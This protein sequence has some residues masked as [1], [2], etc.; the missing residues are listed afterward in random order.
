M[1]TVAII[2]A[3]LASTRL[4][5]K[6][7]LPLP[8]GR[9]VLE[10]VVYR[11]HQVEGVDLVV[12]A[13][14]RGDANKILLPHCG[15]ASTWGSTPDENDVLGRYSDAARLYDADRILRVTS[16][17]PLIDPAQCARVLADR[18]YRYSRLSAGGW[19]C[20]AFTAEA[21]YLANQH[22]ESAHDREHVGPWM[23]ENVRPI[24]LLLCPTNMT[25]PPS[26]DTLDDYIRIWKIFDDQ[27]AADP[28]LRAA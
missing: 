22:A 3:R 21:L 19:S 18:G 20:E 11:C 16:D 10:E 24:G 23:A 2:Q 27:I 9:T 5:A 14:P 8:T 26:L 15:M 4:P 28:S 13:T 6:V 17:C 7:L 25:P 1:K 12:V